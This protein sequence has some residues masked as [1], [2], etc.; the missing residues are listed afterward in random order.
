MVKLAPL[1]DKNQVLASAATV[2][3]A[4]DLET[5]HK[6]DVQNQPDRLILMANQRDL[7]ALKL[8]HL[9]QTN[10]KRKGQLDLRIAL[11]PPTT[12]VV[13]AEEATTE[14]DA[15]VEKAKANKCCS[16]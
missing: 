1:V 6:I 10:A 12:N 8:P 14:E 9:V 2:K 15:H 4:R 7:R 3:N 16:C 13:T 11:Q 5:T